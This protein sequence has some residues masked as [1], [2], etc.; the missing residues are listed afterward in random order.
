[1]CSSTCGTPRGAF[2]PNTTPP[3]SNGCSAKRPSSSKDTPAKSQAASAAKRPKPIWTQR[4]ARTPTTPPTTSPTK[5]TTWTTGPPS[6][7]AGQSRP[8][9]SKE[10]ADTSSKTAWT[11]PEP[12]GAWPAPKPP[13]NYAPSKPTATSTTTGTTTSTKNDTTSTKPATSTTSSHNRHDRSLQKSRTHATVS[14]CS[15]S[16]EERA[17]A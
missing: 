6:P 15:L 16:A 13:S 12:A 9:S 10:H 3:P 7:K 14:A 1:M 4:N 8:E 11:S 2:T 17:P 5:P